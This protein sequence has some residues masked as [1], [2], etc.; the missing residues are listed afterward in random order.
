[1]PFRHRLLAGLV[2]VMWGVNFLAIHLSLE[3]FPPLFLVALRF[4]L[5]AVPTVLFVPRPNVPIRWLVGYGLG[6]GVIQF[7]F[8]YTGMA[9]GMPTG[10]AS[11]VL[12]AS[13]PFTLVLG[14]LLLRERV[15]LVQWAGILLAILGM[16]LVGLSQAEAAQFLPFVLVLVGGLGWA[17]GNL[18]S[19][20]AKPAKPLHL[21]MWMSVVVP[22][23]MLALSL[24]VEG[25]SA[26]GHSL[27]TSWSPAAAP[28][29]AGLVYTV[30]IATV[31][32]SG[33]WTWLLARHPAGVV[34]PFSMLVPIVGILTAAVVL[35]ERPT[36]LEYVGGAIVVT[37]VIVGS[38]L[39]RD[40][41]GPD[42]R[43]D[44]TAD[45][46][47]RDALAPRRLHRTMGAR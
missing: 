28:A 32:G 3:Q 4:A 6:F 20:L 44:R 39:G 36:L 9:A 25:P 37:G 47:P 38:R 18:S 16:G 27:A 8:L 2:A 41:A 34:A 40:T 24:V 29:W 35:G 26:I 46:P 1:M 12:Q 10:L 11:L 22:V 7:T 15:R 30:V 5:L 33:V 43:S 45:G 19:R 14:A 42:P 31:A 23:P 13:G 17:L 21:A